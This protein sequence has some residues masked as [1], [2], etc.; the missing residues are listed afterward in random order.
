M[1]L[2]IGI[3]VFKQEERRCISTTASLHF[4]NW[5][6][7]GS[8]SEGA[9]DRRVEKPQLKNC[10]QDQHRD[11][12]ENTDQHKEAEDGT[13]DAAYESEDAANQPENQTENSFDKSKDKF[14]QTFD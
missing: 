3:D 2:S 14:E 6:E 9:L 13:Q 1:N 7:R 8:V 12:K 11:N 4:V 10:H 5:W